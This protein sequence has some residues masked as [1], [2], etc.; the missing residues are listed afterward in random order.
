MPEIHITEGSSLGTAAAPAGAY[1]LMQVMALPAVAQQV[2]AVGGASAQ[3]AAFGAGTRFIRIETDVGCRIAIGASPTAAATSLPL[4]AGAVEYFAVQ[5]GHR[6]AV[7][8][9]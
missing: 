2:V 7:I 9:R 5:P 1:P 8:A 4:S 6:L 3:S